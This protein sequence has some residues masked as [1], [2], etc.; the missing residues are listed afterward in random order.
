[1]SC[2]G[3]RSQR[4]QAIVLVALIMVVLL[5]FLGLALDGGRAYVDRRQMQA[6]VDAGALAAAFKCM[7]EVSSCMTGTFYA[8]AESSAKVIFGTDER[9]YADP[10]CPAL[11][12][13][14]VT[15]TYSDS[16]GQVLTISVVNRSVAG[17]LFTVTANHRIP[18]VIMPILGS[19]LTI[20]IGATA[21][22]VAR[23]P[24]S[25]AAIQTLSPSGCPGYN[26]DSLRFT[27]TSIAL[28]NG[29]VWSNGDIND[30]NNAG[31]TVSGNVVDVCGAPPALPPPNW[32]VNGSQVNGTT[33]PDPG[34]GAAALNSTPQSWS[35]NNVVRS[36]GAY[37][38]SVNLTSNDL[39]WF[40]AGGAYDFVGGFK[41]SGGFVSN[42]LRPPDEPVYNNNTVRATDQFWDTNLSGY[43][44]GTG[45][46]KA[47]CSGEFLPYAVSDTSGLTAATYAVELTSVRWDPGSCGPPASAS[48][49]LRESSPSMCKTV[50]V[51]GGDVLKIWVSN[52]AGAMGY[53]VYLAP[54][55]SCSGPFGYAGQFTNTVTEQNKTISGCNP[56]LSGLTAPPTLSNCD[57]GSSSGTFNSGS[58]CN[59]IAPNPT[60]AQDTCGAPPPDGEGAP[61]GA[62]LPSTDTAAATYPHGDLANE[63]YCLNG[64]GNPTSCGSGTTTPGAVFMFIPGPGSTSQC[65]DLE[66]GGS[67]YLFSGYQFGHI[68]L[69]EPGALQLPPANTCNDKVTGGNL[70]SLLGIFYIPAAGITIAGN[71]TYAAII[72][73]GVISW[74]A[75]IQGTGGVAI[76]ADQSLRFPGAVQLTK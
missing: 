67:D 50:A 5:G 42:E 64:A 43:G 74:T 62:G 66:G 65:L 9:L 19:G 57:L 73:G 14:S 17:R 45:S 6:A 1:V 29:D 51:A 7:N 69:Y 11:G 16:T 76:S 47:Q 49:F 8:D 33:L 15:C 48:C 23:L 18:V 4:G 71:S 59:G 55:G 44:L 40:M 53:N 21:T 68:L 20:P 25:G 58:T 70:T 30:N 41:N 26:G 31:G 63:Y 35:D 36:P 2:L 72:A 60:A 54:N 52:V 27:G 28:L 24:D 37:N 22:A 12:A 46:N 13:A 34:F 38:G 39:C 75:T 10:S 3:S 56:S 32:T 61:I